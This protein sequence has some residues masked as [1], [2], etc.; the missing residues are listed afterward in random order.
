M[1]KFND[2]ISNSKYIPRWTFPQY[3]SENTNQPYSLSE[4]EFHEQVKLDIQEF[5]EKTPLLTKTL[6]KN[7]KRQLQVTVFEDSTMI[8]TSDTGIKEEI[9][10]TESEFDE[11]KNIINEIEKEPPNC[12]TDVDKSYPMTFITLHK[13]D[14]S[15]YAD[16]SCPESSMKS[17][18]KLNKFMDKKL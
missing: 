2:A 5:N 7:E 10:L 15:F 16:G 18:Y 8:F 6:T 9:K 1:E 14:Q 3:K 12:C 17:Y 11:I 13:L 4:K